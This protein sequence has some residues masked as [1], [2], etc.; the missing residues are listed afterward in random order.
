MNYGREFLRRG[1]LAAAGGPVILAIVYICLGRSGVIESLSVEEVV[2]GILTAALLAFIA[3]GITMIYQVE[4]LSLFSAAT[5]HG[6]VLYL[7]Y[8]LIYLLNGW[9]KADWAHV[10]IY[11]MCF[12]VGYLIIWAFVYRS[13]R[14]SVQKVNQKIA[15]EK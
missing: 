1:L 14:A 8:I 12:V 11:T 6:V 2:L 13:I 10:A 3:G 7:D 4:Q 5:I 15:E 9:L